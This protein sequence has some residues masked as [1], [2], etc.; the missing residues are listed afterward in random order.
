MSSLQVQ[1][2]CDHMLPCQYLTFDEF[3]LPCIHVFQTD[4]QWY[5]LKKI[6]VYTCMF[7]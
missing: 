3:L 5:Q 2:V 7:R 6:C 4:E 1:S